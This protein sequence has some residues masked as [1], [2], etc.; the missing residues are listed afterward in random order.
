M[1]PIQPARSAFLVLAGLALA[2]VAPASSARAADAETDVPDDKR[3]YHL[4][5]PTPAPLLRDLSTDRP[6]ITESP[7]TVDAGRFQVELEVA[8][9]SEDESPIGRA[10]NIGVLGVNAKVGLLNSMDVQLGAGTVRREFASDSL[11]VNEETSGVTDLAV[12][13]KWNL[14]G[15]DR[16]ATAMALMP[17]VTLPTGSE[18]FTSDAVEGGLIAPFGVS[19]P[20]D[21]DMGLMA[22]ADWIKDS[23]GS[24]HHLEWLTTATLGRGLVGSLGA[25]VEMAASFRPQRE[26]DWV[27]TADAGLTFGPTPN[28]QLDAGVL[29]GLSEDADGGTF[30]LGLSL[31]R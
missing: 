12:R 27:G 2:A 23:D 10:K 13:L 11:G 19:L 4:F 20:A 16:G 28:V 3:G 15:N 6:D 5:R 8:S 14:W 9:Y 1:R 17:F 22:E 29:L 30:F 31:R 18:G 7:H 24:G 21:F 26:G 25:F